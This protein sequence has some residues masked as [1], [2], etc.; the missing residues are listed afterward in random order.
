[1]DNRQPSIRQPRSARRAGAKRLKIV[2]YMAAYCG[3]CG[4]AG[5]A[6]CSYCRDRACPT[7]AACHAHHQPRAAGS[8]NAPP[9]AAPW[10][11]M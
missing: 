5:A 9:S 3:V 1:M 4:K 7:S 6:W 11:V 2:D 8:V 10:K